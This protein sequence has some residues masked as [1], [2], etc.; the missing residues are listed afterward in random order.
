MTHT[1]TKVCAGEY[2]YR[3][4]AISLCYCDD[5]GWSWYISA[6]THEQGRSWFDPTETLRQA[7]QAI[8]AHNTGDTQ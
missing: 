4:W 5:W 2:E 3:G 8:D 1:A 7:K 6:T